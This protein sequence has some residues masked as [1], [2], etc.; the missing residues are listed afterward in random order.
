[1]NAA[2][3]QALTRLYLVR[4]E[5]VSS[6]TRTSIIGNSPLIPIANRAANTGNSGVAPSRN[7]P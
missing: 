6:S 3:P 1:M 2:D 7:R 4:S 5:P